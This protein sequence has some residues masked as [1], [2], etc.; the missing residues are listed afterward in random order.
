MHADE[1]VVMVRVGYHVRKAGSRFD[2]AEE[3][4]GRAVQ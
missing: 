4:P 3:C 1:D 2:V